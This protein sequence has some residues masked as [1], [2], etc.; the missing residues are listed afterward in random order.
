MLFPS[1]ASHLS[2]LFALALM[3]TGSPGA[4]AWDDTGHEV[5]AQIAQDTLTAWSKAPGPDGSAANQALSTMWAIIRRDPRAADA[6]HPRGRLFLC[7]TWPDHI[8]LKDAP[9]NAKDAGSGTHIHASWHFVDI[10]Y[11]PPPVASLDTLI[12]LPG[13]TPDEADERSANVVTAIPFYERMLKDATTPL[14]RRAD[15][16]SWLIHLVG[17]VHQPL[18]CVTV[19]PGDTITTPGGYHYTPPPVDAATGQ[20]G[21]RGGNGLPIIG[22]RTSRQDPN[23]P[24]PTTLHAFWDEQLD[25]SGPPPQG[26]ITDLAHEI[27]EMHPLAA[28]DGS[29]DLTPANWAKESYGYRQQA[30]DTP[31]GQQPSADFL[32]RSRAIAD[33]RIALAGYRLAGVVVE[34][35]GQ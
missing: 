31:Q 16:L 30:Y 3:L 23:T 29:H 28:T 21:D 19:S 7:A 20:G 4:F 10:P 17:D 34:A 1:P 27:E 22:F 8:R 11:D 14:A 12:N 15:A 33:L 13:K 24:L 18:H 26:K 25:L 35:L 9:P 32:N 5:I 2:T 6:K